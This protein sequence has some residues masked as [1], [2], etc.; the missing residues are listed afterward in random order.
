MHKSLIYSKNSDGPRIEPCGTPQE[1][2]KKPES[3]MIASFIVQVKELPMGWT[4]LVQKMRTPIQHRT[5]LK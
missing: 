1:T 3:I 4:M 2:G 5:A